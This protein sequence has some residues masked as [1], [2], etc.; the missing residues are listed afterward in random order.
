MSDDSRTAFGL[1]KIREGISKRRAE[2]SHDT[3]PDTKSV[4]SQFADTSFTFEQPDFDRTEPPRDQ[5][6]KYWR[7]FETTPIVRKPITSFASRVIEQGYYFSY[8]EEVRDDK[9]LR[10]KMRHFAQSCGI[11]EGEV[12]QDFTILAKKK[13]IQNEVRGTSLTEKVPDTNDDEVLAGLKLVNPETME[14]VTRPNQAILLAPDDNENPEWEDI[15]ETEDGRAAAYLQDIYETRNTVFN[16]DKITS[17]GVNK[18]PF[19]RDEIVK[20]TRDADVGEVFGT[21]RIEAVSDRVDGIKQKL[22]DHDEAIASK[23]YPLWLF[24]FG[25]PE[26]GIWDRDDIRNFMESHEMSNFHPGM[27]QGVRGDVEVETISGEVAD[28]AESLEFDVN[29]IMSAMPLPK[30]SLGGF[31]EG[32]GQVAGV[33]QQSNVQRQIRETREELE[34]KFEPVFQEKAMEFGVDETVARDIELNFGNRG[35]PDIE[36]NTN[37]QVI[38]YMGKR[39]GD[40]E[41]VRDINPTLSDPQEDDGDEV[42]DFDKDYSSGDEGESS[43]GSNESSTEQS[44]DMYDPR[45]LEQNSVW[46]AEMNVAQLAHYDSSNHEVELAVT[47]SDVATSVREDVLEGMEGDLDIGRIANRAIERYTQDKDFQQAMKDS[48]EMSLEEAEKVYEGSGS[49]SRYSDKSH[50]ERN[51]RNA[52]RDFLE[53]MVRRMRVQMRHAKSTEEGLSD[54]RTRVR[55]E[56]SDSTI[57]NRAKMIARMEC[58]EARESTKMRLFEQNEDI[59]GIRF[60]EGNHSHEVCRALEGEEF[61]FED[62]LQEQLRI[63]TKDASVD[64]GFDPLPLTAPYHMNCTMSMEPV[65][66]GSNDD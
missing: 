34:R 38:R 9:E 8:P 46:D 65:Y 30:Y 22:D 21:S 14:V 61:L 66:G 63:A 25:N 43:D 20:M 36:P 45:D 19:T 5:M 57:H 4:D 33:A 15:P 27:K 32:V 48:V 18:V 35:E 62:D 37:Q 58:R 17:E 47:V 52:V 59:V 10:R 50:F 39:K 16:Y 53:G 31:G 41:G 7:Q 56:F 51:I 40:T 60:P 28:I 3:N 54:V 44:D 55:K 2:L 64:D 1:G 11:V 42:L 6:R 12:N 23:A 29:W 13:V 49:M 26:T 24:M